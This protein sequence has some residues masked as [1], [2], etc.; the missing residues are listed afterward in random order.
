M[1]ICIMYIT[2]K[3]E[4][5]PK[6]VYLLLEDIEL[7]RSF[8]TPISRD[9]YFFRHGKRKGVHKSKRGQF[10]K[11]YLW[12]W[13]RDACQNLGVEGVP[14]YPGTKH[15]TVVALGEEC[16][17]EE[18][19]KYGAGHATNAAF[20]RYFQVSAEKKRELFAKARCTKSP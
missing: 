6:K 20:D 3:K 18:I 5:K 13:W 11:D 14:L 17:S 19:K 2:Y 15:S 10:G 4:R 9:I 16:T 8:P 12:K 7:I 1:F